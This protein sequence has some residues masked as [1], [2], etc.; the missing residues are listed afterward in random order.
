MSRVTRTAA[1]MRKGFL[2]SKPS[3]PSESHTPSPS[4]STTST[5]NRAAA[6]ELV[7][8]AS[9]AHDKGDDTSARRLLLKSLRLCDTP[10]GSALLAA[11]DKFG[12][13]SPAFKAVRRVLALPANCSQY[14]VLDVK[15]TA[16]IDEIKKAYKQRS[17]ELHPDRNRAHNSEDAF[18]RVSAAFK[19]LSDAQSRA[20][21]DLKMGLGRGG[22]AGNPFQGN[23]FQAARQAA[24]ANARRAA[25]HEAQQRRK[26][27]YENPWREWEREQAAKHKPPP[28]PTG[29]PPPSPTGT[30]APSSGAAGAGSAAC[31]PLLDALAHQM[32]LLPNPL[33]DSG[34][35]NVANLR[36]EVAKVVGALE[37]ARA[38]LVTAK[39]AEV[40][41]RSEGAREA[42]AELRALRGERDAFAAQLAEVRS[43]RDAMRA[44]RDAMRSVSDA[45]R[46]ELV[47]E[48]RAVAGQECAFDEVPHKG[49]HAK[50]ES[51]WAARRLRVLERVSGCGCCERV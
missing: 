37:T 44:E 24:E 17:F 42:A 14:N 12:E 39:S 19:V 3:T 46:S 10:S 25:E 13:G 9:A 29:K 35:R 30:G 31:S 8:R 27:Q 38:E 11:L 26:R 40:I 5:A 51:G 16:T 18:K 41:A 47:A 45:L 2:S 43:E 1:L 50:E 34:A 20:A 15:Q 32:R 49:L 33:V 22:S 23:A 36:A 6:E 21:H 28:S 4:P 7:A 48:A